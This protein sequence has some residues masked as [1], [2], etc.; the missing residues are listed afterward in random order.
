VFK[1]KVRRDQ[2]GT[3]SNRGLGVLDKNYVAL[4]VSRMQ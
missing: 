3:D 2:L 4:A 1:R